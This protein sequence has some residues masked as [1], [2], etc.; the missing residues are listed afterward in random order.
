MTK[1]DEDQIPSIWRLQPV[2]K[3]ALT[4]ELIHARAAR[5]DRQMRNRIRIDILSSL[6][7]VICLVIAAVS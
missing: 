3:V 2:P 7:L 6:G 4:L 5:F 1:L